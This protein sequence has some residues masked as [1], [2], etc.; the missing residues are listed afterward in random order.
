MYRLIC[1]LL[2]LS[3]CLQTLAAPP[4]INNVRASQRPGTKLVD[5][6]YDLSDADGDLQLVQVAASSDAGL[7]Y[8][9]PCVT[10]TGAV[11]ANVSQGTNRHIVWNAGAD[12]DGNWVAQ[13]R[14]RV[15]AHDG[16]TPPAP[17]G[18]VYI[19]PGPFQ[20]GDNLDDG[21]TDE[22]PVHTVQLSGYFMDKKEVTKELWEQV[23]AWGNNN[24]YSIAGGAAKASGHPVYGV[25]WYNAAIWCNARSA[26]EGLTPCY[27]TDEAQ[28]IIYKG[29]SVNLTNTMVK[30]SANGYRLPT[31]AEWE[32]AARGGR[33]GQRFPHGNTISHSDANFAN[34]G[35]EPYQSGTTGFHPAY[36]PYSP[37]TSPAGSFPQNDYGLFDMAGNVP[38]WV[39]DWYDGA[40]YGNSD[41]LN[42]PV[43]PQTGSSRAIRSADWR[44]YATNCRCSDRYALIPSSSSWNTNSPRRLGFRA[45]RK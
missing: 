6:Y 39:W 43:G 34:S 4:V 20:M 8:G 37:F 9:I 41:S 28:T 5:I 7:T 15:T 11:G 12:W 14:V 2:P 26:R 36:V 31:E 38:E 10:L 16:T 33:T 23:K 25:N 1:L 32:K 45:V 35:N 44:D 24:G 27:Y 29:G 21:S 19:P 22:L 18:M 30:W 13:C 17:P 40:F 42:D 3:L